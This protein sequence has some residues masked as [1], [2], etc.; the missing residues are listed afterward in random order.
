MT[1]KC[2]A[3]AHSTGNRALRR[4]LWLGHHSLMR[5]PLAIDSGAA[6]NTVAKYASCCSEL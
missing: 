3:R 1:G 2:T 5:N 6:M 4:S